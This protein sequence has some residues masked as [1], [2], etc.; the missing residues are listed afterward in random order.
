MK[1]S[2]DET[3]TNFSKLLDQATMFQAD[4][5]STR[6]ESMAINKNELTDD[7][8][9]GWGSVDALATASFTF[10]CL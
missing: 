5:I 6:V 1:D 4:K 3:I 8:Y 10:N 2:D 9:Q 7:M